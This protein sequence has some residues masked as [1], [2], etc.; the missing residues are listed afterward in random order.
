MAKWTPLAALS[1]GSRTSS[2]LNAVNMAMR[3]V[4]QRLGW[5]LKDARYNLNSSRDIVLNKATK[6]KIVMRMSQAS[7]RRVTIV[8]DGTHS[9]A[10]DVRK[11]KIVAERDL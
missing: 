3:A 4:V 11:K 10:Y 2:T 8:V 1:L 6:E 9:Y 5:R 7:K